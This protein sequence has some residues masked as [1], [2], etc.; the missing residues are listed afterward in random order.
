MSISSSRFPSKWLLRLLIYLCSL[1]PHF[2]VKESHLIVPIWG[3]L[4]NNIIE[5]FNS[6]PWSSIFGVRYGL[7]LTNSLITIIVT[8]KYTSQL[9]Q[10]KT[11]I[12]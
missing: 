2:P 8:S 5:D 7:D 11:H 6:P 10:Y 12:V 4:V 3:K 9:E 1:H